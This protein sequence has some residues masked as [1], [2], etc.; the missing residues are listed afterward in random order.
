MTTYRGSIQHPYDLLEAFALDALDPA[1]EQV[2]NDHLEWCVNCDAIVNE[3]L[4]VATAFAR[5]V[6]EQ[7]PPEGLRTRILDVLDT[8]GTPPLPTRVS[9]SVTAPRAPRSWSR[10][11]SVFTGRWVRVLAPATTVLAA[12][13]IAIT[14]VLNLQMAGDLDEVQAEN[15][16]LQQ[17]LD[18]SMATTSALASSTDRVAQM[19]GSLQQ[20][21]QAGHAL[22]QPGD[23]IIEMRAVQRGMESGRLLCT[24]DDCSAGVLLVSGLMAPQP[25]SAYHVWLNRGGQL[26]WAGEIVANERGGG[27]LPVPPNTQDSLTLFD[28]IMVSRG[29]GVAAAMAAPANSAERQRATASMVGDM[30]LVAPLR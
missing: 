22:A 12:A 25:D 23:R 17:R 16:Q 10:V 13:F 8:P 21:Q 6:P 3:N 29:M 30:V 5:S 11:S 27:L 18:Q 14:V 26:Y 9:V 1:E 19:Q 20:W 24:S 15:S 2:V 4:R 28:S 7:A